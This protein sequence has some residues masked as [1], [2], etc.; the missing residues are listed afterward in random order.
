MENDV[1]QTSKIE[2]ENQEIKEQEVVKKQ[3]T[4]LASEDMEEVKRRVGNTA[5]VMKVIGGLSII[6]G[7]LCLICDWFVNYYC[8]GSKFCYN[9]G[10]GVISFLGAFFMSFLVGGIVMSKMIKNRKKTDKATCYAVG[11]AVTFVCAL[12][13]YG[14]SWL[15]RLL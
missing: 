7:I 1:E 15:T 12:V 13:L 6:P 11:W 2:T 10:P 4:D 9:S 14:L 5:T 3:V 8:A